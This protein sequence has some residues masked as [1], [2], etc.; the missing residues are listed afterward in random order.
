MEMNSYRLL[1]SE[2]ALEDVEFFKQSGQVDIQNKISRLLKDVKE[3]PESGLGKPEKL[4]YT[5][6]GCMSRRINREHRL[7]YKIEVATH[8]VKILSLRFHY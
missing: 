8:T 1:F 3:H 4:K 6:S 5:L 2:Q 7:L